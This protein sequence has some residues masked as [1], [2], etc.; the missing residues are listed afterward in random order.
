[1]FMGELEI[2]S[3][4]VIAELLLLLKEQVCMRVST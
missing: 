2:A 1:M 4:C 3:L